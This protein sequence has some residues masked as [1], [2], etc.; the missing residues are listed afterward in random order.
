MMGK[1]LMEMKRYKYN[2]ALQKKYLETGLSLSHYVKYLIAFFGFASRDVKTTMIIA[3]I[4]AFLCLI[5]GRLWFRYK[6]IHTENEIINIFNPF[7]REVREH[8]KKRNI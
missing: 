3:I 2:L 8:I 4:Y 7:Q 6:L 1:A 5:L